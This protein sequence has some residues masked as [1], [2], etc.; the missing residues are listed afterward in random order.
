MGVA[1]GYGKLDED[2]V[3]SEAALLEAVVVSV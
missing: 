2:V 1:D 3:V